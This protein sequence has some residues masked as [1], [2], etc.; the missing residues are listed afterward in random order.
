MN[1]VLMILIHVLV[2]ES[3][4]PKN[5]IAET[6]F[7][8]YAMVSVSRGVLCV[9][10]AMNM[11]RCGLVSD[12]SLLGSCSISHGNTLSSQKVNEARHL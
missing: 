11:D 5:F 4:C 12:V 7:P 9:I 2:Q 10:P 3:F 8:L 1:L 6:T